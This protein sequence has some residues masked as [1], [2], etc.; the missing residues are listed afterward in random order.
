MKILIVG[1]NGQVG[2]ELSSA[3]SDLKVCDGEQTQI[4]MATRED[5]DLIETTKIYRS[6]ASIAPRF[7]H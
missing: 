1:A 3:L 2:S 5:L 7:S 4:V 6:L